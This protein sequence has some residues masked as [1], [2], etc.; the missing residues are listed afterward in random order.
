MEKERNHSGAPEAGG[1]TT[2]HSMFGGDSLLAHA[3]RWMARVGRDLEA[4]AYRRL[5]E[6]ERVRTG[7]KPSDSPGAPRRARAAGRIPN[8]SHLRPA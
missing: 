3:L 8:N 2:R 7:G 1:A 4:S 6:L 5:K